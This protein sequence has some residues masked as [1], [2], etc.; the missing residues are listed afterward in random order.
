M[1]KT[2]VLALVAICAW[3]QT[4]GTCLGIPTGFSLGANQGT[5]NGFKPLPSSV[6]WNAIDT[7]PVD[8]R[9]AAW[10]NDF[11]FQQG[12][13]LR[14]RSLYPSTENGSG[15][16]NV[17]GFLYHVV[18]G[19]QLRRNVP[20]YDSGD[21]IAGADVDPGPYPMPL[22]ARVKNTL[23]VGTTIV[24]PSKAGDGHVIVIDKDNCLGYV[25]FKARHLDGEATQAAYVAVFDLLGGDNQRPY[26]KPS[27]SV[28]GLP[29]FPNYTLVNRDEITAGQ[30][31]HPFFGTA[32]VSGGGNFFP[33][34]SFL[35]PASA[36]QYGNGGWAASELP[37]GARIRMK[38]TVNTSTW[39]AQAKIFGAALKKYGVL[40]GDG[41]GTLD[42][43]GAAS[44]AWDHNTTIFFYTNWFAGPI[45]MEIP[46]TGSVYCDPL[47]VLPSNGGCPNPPPSGP[48]PVISSFAASAASVAP[49]QP[50][51]LSWNVSGAGSRIRFVTPEVGPVVT[52]ST[53]VQPQKTT[54]YTLMVENKSG[55][56]T[57]TVNVAVANPTTL[58]VG[59]KQNEIVGEA[60]VHGTITNSGGSAFNDC[61]VSPCPIPLD[62]SLDGSA[63]VIQYR[64]A[65]GKVVGATNPIAVKVK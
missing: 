39:P 30:I 17:E 26:M 35:T 59:T 50:V 6:L 5:L 61:S 52:N 36:H 48:V 4:P 14:I 16:G 49:G 7:D 3:S 22:A 41:G 33:H 65:G 56:T 60:A 24:D 21:G 11:V 40:I 37:F 13:D 9:S 28:S 1:I 64:S 8:S 55:R 51:T 15:T 20:W 19:T 34:H 47:Y 32:F 25:F 43:Y 53:I 54:V 63:L 42:L 23:I 44:P 46:Q 38:S 29:L 27:G 45:S 10:M 18:S 57:A 31:N 2:I 12:I 58:F 62:S